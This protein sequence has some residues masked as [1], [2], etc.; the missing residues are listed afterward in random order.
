MV[1]NENKILIILF[2]LFILSISFTG[3]IES[4]EL[5]QIL[6]E[7]SLL[8][9]YNFLTQEKDCDILESGSTAVPFL[10][11]ELIQQNKGFHQIFVTFIL[12]M[13]LAFSITFCIFLFT[14]YHVRG[15]F[16][17]YVYDEP[18]KLLEKTYAYQNN[19]VKDALCFIF[20]STLVSVLF[21]FMILNITG[22]AALERLYDFINTFDLSGVV[23]ETIEQVVEDQDKNQASETII[24]SL[25]IFG[26]MVF[27]FGAIWTFLLRYIM[28]NRDKKNTNNKKRYFTG[29]KS[30][31][32][33]IYFSIAILLLLQFLRG[34]S[35]FDFVLYGIPIQ[36]D[37]T[38][39]VFIVAIIVGGMAS[40]FFWSLDRFVFNKFQK[41]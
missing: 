13:P 24:S 6:V 16:F 12:L 4:M 11:G 35:I 33:F 30:M 36:E 29:S 32:I 37:F 21:V 20:L 28:A 39:F 34:D 10:E 26:W 38:G 7:N 23:S 25:K 41:I 3:M 27:T 22:S 1:K 2:G 31:L 15:K 18:K 9:C 40:L 19:I 8:T 5:Q 17:T 14:R